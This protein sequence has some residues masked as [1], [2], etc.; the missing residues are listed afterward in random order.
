MRA[1]RADRWRPPFLVR[2]I[3]VRAG[4]AFQI[5][6]FRRVLTQ[7]GQVCLTKSLQS[8]RIAK[9]AVLNY[10]GLV[11][12]LIFGVTFFGEH[13]TA[14]TVLGISLVVAGVLLSLPAAAGGPLR[15]PRTPE[16]IEE[17]ETA[18]V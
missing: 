15:K 13:Y 7:V 18:V 2:D 17:T 14:Q 8:E 1:G 10:I 9:V 6:A 12:A 16:V 4:S 11:Y 3:A 5:S